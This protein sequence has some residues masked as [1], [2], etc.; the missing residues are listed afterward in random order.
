[1]EEEEARRAEEQEKR[2]ALKVLAREEEQ[3]KAELANQERLQREEAKAVLRD[4]RLT[5]TPHP[6][7]PNHIVF[8]REKAYVPYGV[9]F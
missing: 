8:Y 2:E 7:N 9:F 1:M 6:G 3:R 5:D 4:G